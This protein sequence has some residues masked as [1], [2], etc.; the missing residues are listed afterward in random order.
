MNHSGMT[1]GW[2]G[3]RFE[4][5]AA[6]S[7]T[8]SPWRTARRLIVAAMMIVFF[9]L[10]VQESFRWLE[11]RAKWL[12]LLADQAAAN[13]PP[14]VAPLAAQR[15]PVPA[16]VAPDVAPDFE[17]LHAEARKRHR[18]FHDPVEAHK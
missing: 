18:E 7:L 12:K 6:A 16:A 17:A 15:A 8:R 13:K 11:Q 1:S 10:A 2:T 4:L 3:S 14:A 5:D 9:L